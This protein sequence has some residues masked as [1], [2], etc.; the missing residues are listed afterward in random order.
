MSLALLAFGVAAMLMSTLGIAALR[1]GPGH[2]LAAGKDGADTAR[3]CAAC[4]RIESLRELD[5]AFAAGKAIPIREFTVRMSDGSSR[6]FREER[7]VGWRL[8]ERLI[9]IDGASEPE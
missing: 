6:V 1:S 5:A 8:G 7:A 9:Y 2:D 4:G 3:R